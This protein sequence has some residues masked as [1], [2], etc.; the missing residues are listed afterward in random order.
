[1]YINMYMYFINETVSLQFLSSLAMHGNILSIF[2]SASSVAAAFHLDSHHYNFVDPGKTIAGPLN[3]L[4]Q[5]YG[6]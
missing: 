5:I 3:K 6:S 2:F 1:M 4:K